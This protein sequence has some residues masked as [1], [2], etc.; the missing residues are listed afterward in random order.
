MC[1]YHNMH[2]YHIFFSLIR[3]ALMI[4][5]YTEDDDDDDLRHVI[6]LK[7]TFFY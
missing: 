1:Q 5:A 6:E 7:E 2:H 3:L 4:T